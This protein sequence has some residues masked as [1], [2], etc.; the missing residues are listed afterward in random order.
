[1][2]KTQ[3]HG[4]NLSH[5]SKW[6]MIFALMAIVGGSC[7]NNTN[8]NPSVQAPKDT[9]YQNWLN[10]E[11]TFKP[12]VDS[13]T[14]AQDFADAKMHLDQYV[15][16]FNN[17]KSEHFKVTNWRSSQRGDSLHYGVLVDLQGPLADSITPPAPVHDGP[18]LL[19]DTQ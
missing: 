10:W 9:V 13:Q 17:K 6:M 16:S 4:P 8:N 2:I 12:M 3:L 5:Y 7:N 11:I 14:R 19:N 18:K 1:M 15:D